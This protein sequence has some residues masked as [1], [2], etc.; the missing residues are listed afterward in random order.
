M[1]TLIKSS[2]LNIKNYISIDDINLLL[3]LSENNKPISLNFYSKKLSEIKI[4]NTSKCLHCDKIA[5][6]KYND[7]LYCWTHAHTL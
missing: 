1:K 5:Q 2:K 7:N 6:Y 4:K 3:K